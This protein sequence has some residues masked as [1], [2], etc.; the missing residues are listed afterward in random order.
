MNTPTKPNS[1]YASSMDS[2]DRKV[3][4]TNAD[5][6]FDDDYQKSR[7][8][9][10]A[11]DYKKSRLEQLHESFTSLSS[12]DEGDAIA[13]PRKY[14]LSELV[15]SLGNGTDMRSLPSELQRRARDFRLAQQKRLETHGEPKRYGIFGMY[16]HLASV[17]V[18][19]EWAE[20]AAWRRSNGEPYLSW[21]DFD[22]AR[23]KGSN[24][25][26]FT[27][28]LIVVCSIMMIV[29]I[30]L[31]GWKFAPLSV[32]P[33][34]GPS[35]EALIKAGAR[36]TALIVESGQWFRI[37]S[38]M[39]LHAGLVHWL[40]NMLAL[41]YIGG[42]IE[43]SHGIVNAVVLFII[44]GV[45]GNILSAIFLPQYISVGASGGIFG[46]IGGCLADISINWNLIFIKTDENDHA[47]RRNIAAIFWLFLDI[48]LNIVFGLTPFIDNF[49][50]LGG[51]ILGLCCGWSTI[52]PLAVGF[53]GNH[54]S[55][56][57]KLRT[58]FV[59]YFGLIISVFL[60]MVS[61]IWLASSDA[62][63]TPC[64]GC[65]FISCAPFPF[66]T[67]N[68]W[69]YC[70][71]CDFVSADL[72]KNSDGD[73]FYDRIEVTCPS[74]N[75]ENIDISEELLSDRVEVRI[76]LPSY[77]RQYCDGVFAN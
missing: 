41:Y 42:A 4:S 50:H 10:F 59:R 44:P 56:A 9:T 31:N 23:Q 34:I 21:K 57:S 54:A 66:W 58:L 30:G 22:E 69:W 73:N 1:H 62:G 61:T 14:S 20:D 8:E 49:T 51:G 16:A 68:K 19:L 72:Y 17:R 71:D 47:W 18:D 48:L 60:I 77:C 25:P 28:V 46:L 45:G 27:Y 67:E 36:D 65:R 74:G 55:T 13:A 32:N 29:E 37:F 52:E 63:E 38:P 43:Q 15:N 75:V 70:D 5:L 76:Q 26:F 53:F 6:T 39:I 11:D 12:S 24:R 64:N 7:L 33:M 3:E 2:S 40:V 35:A